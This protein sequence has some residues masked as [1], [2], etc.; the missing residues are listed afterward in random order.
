MKKIA[1][2]RGVTMLVIAGTLA[3]SA[4]AALAAPG[5]IIFERQ[6]EAA[7]GG[8]FE[9]SIFPHWVHRIRYRCYVCHETLFEMKKG[10]NEV[11]MEKMNKGQYCGACH[12]GRQ[13]FDVSFENCTRCHVEP[14]D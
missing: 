9:P 3:L 5:D 11:T 1:R 13:A 7:E 14:Q 2:F 10:A 4:A 6:G 12:N 8:A